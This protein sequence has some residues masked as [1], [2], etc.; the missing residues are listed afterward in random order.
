MSDRLEEI[1]RDYA[2]LKEKWDYPVE[3]VE[4]LISEVE[5]LHARFPAEMKNCTIR[6]L[7]CPVGHGRLTADNWID[8]GCKQCEVERL[9]NYLAFYKSTAQELRESYEKATKRCEDAREVFNAPYDP[10]SV[11]KWLEGKP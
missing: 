6:F 4:W 5:R 3:A 8:N 9:T 11:K 7:E 1:K 10:T 2:A